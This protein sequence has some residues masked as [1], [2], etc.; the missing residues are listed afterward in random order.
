MNYFLGPLLIVLMIMVVVSLVRGVIAFLQSAREDIDRD[1]NS[2]KPSAL[3]LRQNQMMFARI[4]Y[5]ALAIVVV[6]VILAVA[7]SNT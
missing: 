1:P 2:T 7:G 3:Q 5:Q 4:K 6:V